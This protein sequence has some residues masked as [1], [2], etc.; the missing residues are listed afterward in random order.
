M[1]QLALAASLCFTGVAAFAQETTLGTVTVQ[2]TA[3]TPL[4]TDVAP[5]A[6]FTAPLLDTPKTVQ[7]INE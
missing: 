7:V 3:E 1:T 5:S 6:K 2:S 4:K